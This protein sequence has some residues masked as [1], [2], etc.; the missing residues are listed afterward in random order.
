[1][2]T[3]PILNGQIL[4]SIERHEQIEKHGRTPEHDDKWFDGELALQAAGLTLMFNGSDTVDVSDSWGLQEKHKGDRIKRLVIAGALI[5][6][7]IDRLQRIENS[8]SET[9]VDAWE[10]AELAKLESI[11]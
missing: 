3:E 7:E 11:Q 1:M 8:D 4:I 2:K 6:A 10:T 9:S 5:A